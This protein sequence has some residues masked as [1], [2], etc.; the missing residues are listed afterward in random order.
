MINASLGY[1]I[2]NIIKI[3]EQILATQLFAILQLAQKAGGKYSA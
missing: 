3:I 2:A 1:I